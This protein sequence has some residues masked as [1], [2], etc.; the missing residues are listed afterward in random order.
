MPDTSL[1]TTA[2][3]P[4]AR[5]QDHDRRIHPPS[6]EPP[7]LWSQKKFDAALSLLECRSKEEFYYSLVF[8]SSKLTQLDIDH[9]RVIFFDLVLRDHSLVDE[10]E[11]LVHAL[12]LDTHLDL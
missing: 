6:L 12:L 2:P 7:C 11:D 8:T 10:G 3:M 1:T 4:R 9:L 5:E